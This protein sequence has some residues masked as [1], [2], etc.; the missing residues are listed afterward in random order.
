MVI[1]HSNISHTI[2]KRRALIIDYRF[3]GV[4]FLL[5]RLWILFGRVDDGE[6]V[7]PRI[8]RVIVDVARDEPSV[9]RR[10]HHEV[11]RS[12]LLLPSLDKQNR[13]AVDDT[14][15]H[16]DYHDKEKDHE[17]ADLHGGWPP[18]LIG[19]Q[20]AKDSAPSGNALSL[21]DFELDILKQ[22]CF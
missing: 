18:V 11:D 7:L 17:D 2:V 13:R 15:K 10:N 21:L 3:F 1:A 19:A 6:G 4:F 5:R 9:V 12:D 22:L 16:R 14:L 8:E 20:V